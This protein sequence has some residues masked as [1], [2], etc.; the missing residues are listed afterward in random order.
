VTSKE[1]SARRLVEGVSESLEIDPAKLA[2][3]AGEFITPEGNQVY[4][5]RLGGRTEYV[6]VPED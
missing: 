6:T 3:V 5:V 2:R 4:R 1:E